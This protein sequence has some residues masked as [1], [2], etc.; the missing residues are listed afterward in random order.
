MPTVFVMYPEKQNVISFS[1][2]ELN[3]VV[4]KKRVSGGKG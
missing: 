2:T 4:E 3:S 1:W